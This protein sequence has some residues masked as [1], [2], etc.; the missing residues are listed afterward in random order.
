M[1]TKPKTRKALVKI[2][3]LQKAA[4]LDFEPW[5]DAVAA[6]RDQLTQH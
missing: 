2:T 3:T 6:W 1:T 5:Q 4:A